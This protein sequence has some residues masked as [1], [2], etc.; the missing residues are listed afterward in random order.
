M[1]TGVV[2]DPAPGYCVRWIERAD[3]DRG[4]DG[5]EACEV[6]HG[7]PKALLVSVEHVSGCPSM[8]IRARYRASFGQREPSAISGGEVRVRR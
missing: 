7:A 8:A 6:A 1:S 3:Y 2:D 5:N 4:I